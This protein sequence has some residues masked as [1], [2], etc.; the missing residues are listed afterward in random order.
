VPLS[1]P[2]MSPLVIGSTVS[3]PLLILPSPLVSSFM[4][5]AFVFF[6]LLLTL[7]HLPPAASP[8]PL[9]QLIQPTSFPVHVSEISVGSGMTVWSVASPISS[10]VLVA[11]PR[12]NL[13]SFPPAVPTFLLSYRSHPSLSIWSFPTLP[14]HHIL[15]F[16]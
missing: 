1:V 15:F 11:L 9:S 6:F 13:P 4:P 14:P 5:P 2:H 3:L 7:F 10:S 8:L 16:P 12:L